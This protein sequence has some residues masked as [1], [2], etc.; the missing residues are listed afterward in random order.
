MITRIWRSYTTPDNAEAYE[1][2]LDTLMFPAIEG[3]RLPGY[4]NMELLRRTDA[5]EV[6]YIWVMNF[7]TEKN[8][9]PLKAEADDPV[10]VPRA[11]QQLLTRW[12]ERAS[13]YE[14]RKSRGSA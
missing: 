4:K 14:T 2:L 11:A 9:S 10:S 13:F 6:E 7:D 8:L 5:G 12:D 3:L 1:H